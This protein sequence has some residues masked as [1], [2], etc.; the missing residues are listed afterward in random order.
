MGERETCFTLDLIN[1]AKGLIYHNQLGIYVQSM[2]YRA[3]KLFYIKTSAAAGR[4]PL[5]IQ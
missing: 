3:R 1:N 5:A 2:L 4:H